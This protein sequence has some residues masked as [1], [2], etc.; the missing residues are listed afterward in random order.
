MQKRQVS[1]LEQYVETPLPLSLESRGPFGVWSARPERVTSRVRIIAPSR[2]RS[3]SGV[4]CSQRGKPKNSLYVWAGP[5]TEW[6]KECDIKLELASE[7]YE[8]REEVG[9]GDFEL[10]RE[11]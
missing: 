1:S 9:E 3:E 10:A 7:F 5:N 8:M 4:S 2:R 6:L 11:L